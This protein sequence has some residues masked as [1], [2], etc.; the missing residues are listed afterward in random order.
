MEWPKSNRLER[1]EVRASRNALGDELRQGFTRCRCVEDA[2]DAMA[3]RNVDAITLLDLADQ[4][5]AVVCDWPEA[6]L[7]RD[8]P[9]RSEHRG[10]SLGDRLETI[11]LARI[12]RD[13]GGGGRE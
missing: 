3:G 10:E 6:G 5:Q 11:D 4:R 13:R 9:L 7:P 2:P 8:D 12:R 1:R